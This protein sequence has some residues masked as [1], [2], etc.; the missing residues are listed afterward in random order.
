MLVE[1]NLKSSWLQR[2]LPRSGSQNVSGLIPASGEPQGRVVLCAHLDSHRTPI[3]YSSDKWQKAFS[4]LIGLTLFSMGLGAL[5]YTLGLALNWGTVRWLGI[6]LVP[7]QVFALAMCLHADFTPYSPGANDNASGTAVLLAV[8]RMLNKSPL[9]NLEV[10]FAFTGCEEVW[11]YGMR[12]YLDAHEAD[13]GD[14]TF[15]IILDQVGS[16][17]LKFLTSDGLMIKH[18]T[19]MRALDIARQVA[20]ASQSWKSFQEPVWL[21]P[22]HSSLPSAD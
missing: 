7:I 14:K 16:G 8:A 22:M 17:R 13:L 19:H 11:A 1:T 12:A 20:V 10:H 5:G 18:K 21:T 4:L 3:F 15:Y 6:L 9:P 2:L